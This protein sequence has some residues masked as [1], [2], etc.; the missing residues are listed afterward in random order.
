MDHRCSPN[1]YPDWTDSR[2]SSPARDQSSPWASI[3]RALGRLEMGQH[4]NR[5][6]GEAR[7]ED[8]RLHIDARIT[9]LR[10]DMGGRLDRMDRRLVSVENRDSADTAPTPPSTPPAPPSTPWW[11]DMSLRERLM[12]SAAAIYVALALVRPDVAAQIK[13]ELLLPLLGAPR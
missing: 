6:A 2:P 8:L 1:G 9:D 10:H 5:K 13:S 11:S 12:W 3:E 4:L 7:V